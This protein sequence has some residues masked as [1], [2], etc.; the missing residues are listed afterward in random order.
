MRL[1]HISDLHFGHH[2]AAIS[3]TLAADVASQK[4]DVLVASGDFTQRGTAR[5]FEQARAFLDSIAVPIFAVPGNHDLGKHPLRRFLDPYRY[6]R[7]YID[8]QIEPFLEVDGLAIAGLNTTR[9]IMLDRDWSNGS[10]NEQQ[11][12]ALEE[13]FE[14]ARPDALRIVVAHHPLMEPEGP[15]QRS[16]FA[17][18]RSELALRSFAAMGV[19]L[20]LSGHFHLSFVRRYDEN[21]VRE[22]IPPG[23]REAA[24]APILVA[25]A[26]SV[27][28][29][30]LRGEPNAYNV[31]DI[32]DGTIAIR[33]REWHEGKWM[34][35]E[36][37]M[38]E[39]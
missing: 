34:T 35:R 2:D 1:A 18:R 4:P 21:A 6:Y 24:S 20:V 30:R 29:T 14:S 5:E 7:R 19:R 15:T 12:A 11:I 28:S 9:R 27:I 37:A 23:P 39:L 13:K 3:D 31:I 36:R 32:E 38:A 26:S 8:E 22:G 33:V 16:T 25:Q 17:V 10:I